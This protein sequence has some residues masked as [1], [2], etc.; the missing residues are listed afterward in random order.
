MLLL[1]HSPWQ[2]Q[3]IVSFFLSSPPPPHGFSDILCTVEGW[4]GKHHRV[5]PPSDRTGGEEIHIFAREVSAVFA[6]PQTE[7]CYEISFSLGPVTF[8]VTDF[9]HKPVM[10]S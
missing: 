3:E 7:K 4:L 8:K 2:T 9:L 1:T 6:P 10:H 5:E